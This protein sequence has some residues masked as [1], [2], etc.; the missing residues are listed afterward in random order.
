MLTSMMN[1]ALQ[2]NQSSSYPK[3]LAGAFRVASSWTTSGRPIISG[4]HHSAFLTDS[5]FVTKAKDPEKGSK[6]PLLPSDEK[7]SKKSSLDTIR[8]YVCG[9]LGHYAKDCRSR[10]DSHSALVVTKSQ[11]EY[12]EDEIEEYEDESVYLTT[13]ETVLFTKNHV[14]LDNQATVNIFNNIDLLKNIRKSNHTILLNGVQ[15]NADPI[16]V[17]LVG[18]FNE[19]GEVFYSDKASANILSFA[20]MSDSGARIEYDHKQKRFTLCPKGSKLIY[21]FCRLPVPGSEGRFYSCDMSSMV[22]TKKTT[23]RQESAL[24]ST[25]S[26]NMSKFTKREIE[27]AGKAKELLAR[28]GYPSVDSAM[29]I[30]R[31]GNNFSVSEND[32]R[33]AHQI[34]GKDVASLKGKTHK[35]VTF[36]PNIQLTPTL[37]Q[38]QQILAI[39]IMFIDQTY[40]LIG[41]STPLDLTLAQSL[42]NIDFKKPS[43]AAAILKPA[44]AQMISTLAS[45]NFVVQLIMSDGEGAI[46]NL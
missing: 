25:V 3:T 39:D 1:R 4:E 11:D 23:H 24:V 31:S 34:W 46:G 35:K 38:V 13:H 6:T 29:S 37:V 17:D 15:A 40:T 32:F 20:A 16:E 44:L 33:I 12:N 28:M 45:R 43:K 21:S 22:S 42:M 7:K 9:K 8:C 19:L 30:L 2:N 10:K 27:S 18:D 41:I 5:A 26:E 36:Q 14:L